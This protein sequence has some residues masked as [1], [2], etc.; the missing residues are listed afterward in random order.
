MYY[1]WRI[2]I[3]LKLNILVTCGC[4]DLCIMLIEIIPMQK[5]VVQPVDQ[6]IQLPI[7]YNS[8]TN[9]CSW[10]IST[11]STSLYAN[12]LNLNKLTQKNDFP[13]ITVIYAWIRRFILKKS[14][15]VWMHWYTS[16]HSTIFSFV[17]LTQFGCF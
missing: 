5:G 14:S 7:Y 1:I 13:W 8:L 2:W 12:H 9:H 17:T 3:L 15:I 16:T 6:T 4:W 10:W 11:K